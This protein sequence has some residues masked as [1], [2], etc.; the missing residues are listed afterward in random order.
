[1]LTFTELLACLAG[2][3]CLG[4]L[5]G[6]VIDALRRRRPRFTISTLLLGGLTGS[7]TLLILHSPWVQ[8]KVDNASL[9]GSDLSTKIARLLT[10]HI[11][12]VSATA[13]ILTTG[14][15]RLA[16]PTRDK[17]GVVAAEPPIGPVYRSVTLNRALLIASEAGMGLSVLAQI[18]AVAFPSHAPSSDY[19]ALVWISLA[20][21]V[22]LWC[23]TKSHFKVSADSTNRPLWIRIASHCIPL[24]VILLMTLY[25]LL[26]A[27]DPSVVA[28]ESARPFAIWT[29]GSAAYHSLNLL[30]KSALSLAFFHLVFMELTAPP[31]STTHPPSS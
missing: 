24:E 13:A 27:P 16:F 12:V 15:F 28:A 25:G 11:Y 31:S 10:N 5:T 6:A 9:L 19:N 21:T 17:R 26:I 4:V 22:A 14:L 30:M 20:T 29:I 7:F 23:N 3:C 2:C 8:D 18:V 1:M